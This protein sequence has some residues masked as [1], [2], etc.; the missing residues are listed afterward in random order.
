MENLII[1]DSALR[2][3]VCKG[4]TIMGVTIDD[5]IAEDILTKG[6][7]E[8]MLLTDNHGQSSY[9]RFTFDGHKVIPVYEKHY[10]DERCPQCS[11]KV[12]ITANAYCC[13]NYLRNPR[14]CNFHALKKV[15]HRLISKDEM[16]DCL[17]HNREILDGFSTDEG[18]LYSGILELNRYGMTSVDSRVFRCPRCGGR[19]LVHQNTFNC[20]NYND[21]VHPC[22]TRIYRDNYGHRM[23]LKELIELLTFGKTVEPLELKRNNG[24]IY[25]AY[26]TFDKAYCKVGVQPA[27]PA[28]SGRRGAEASNTD[29]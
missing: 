25:P 10:L 8:R 11:G 6:S 28:P 1:P 16:E 17:R 21:P 13:E 22:K 18:K 29:K 20:E 5:K 26:L 4:S 2:D 27:S 7:S 9:G 24:R 15:G 23:T 3:A 14:K 12:I 19:L